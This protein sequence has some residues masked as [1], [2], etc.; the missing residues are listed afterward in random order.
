[1]T[2]ATVTYM[3]HSGEQSRAGFFVEQLDAS[4]FSSVQTDIDTI[5]LAIDLLSNGSKAQDTWTA[6]KRLYP[7]TLPNDPTA[8][9]EIKALVTYADDV[10]GN[11][12]QLTIPVFNYDGVQQGTDVI[13]L[14]AGGWPGFI[15]AFEGGG[16]SPAGN[17]VTVLGAVLVGRNN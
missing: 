15:N 12:Y 13:D 2:N 5:I 17:S 3:D 1:M 7:F 6:D 16:R 9:R 4:N 10:T 14:S 8:Q 11:R